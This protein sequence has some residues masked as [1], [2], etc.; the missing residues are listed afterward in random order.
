M[1]I[2]FAYAMLDEIGYKPI[3]VHTANHSYDSAAIGIVSIYLLRHNPAYFG[4]LMLFSTISNALDEDTEWPEGFGNLALGT[5]VSTGFFMLQNDSNRENIMSGLAVT[6][7]S[8]EFFGSFIPQDTLA[9]AKF[10][11]LNKGVFE[12]KDQGI[13]IQTSNAIY[14]SLRKHG[15]IRNTSAYN[16]RFTEKISSIQDI[17]NVYLEERFSEYK[18]YIV[19]VLKQIYIF[20]TTGKNEN[21][22]Y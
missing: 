10:A 12:S 5:G 22:V 1:G 16:G 19:W 17:D 7:L 9:D 15:Y 11:I 2:N 13:S 4:G 21:V 8:V 3:V 6:F 18:T 14:R 20:Q